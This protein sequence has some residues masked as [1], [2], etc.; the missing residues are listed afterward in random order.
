MS[1]N[2]KVSVSVESK[3]QERVEKFL[4]KRKSDVQEIADSISRAE[5][6]SIKMMGEL[7]KKSAGNFGMED[8]KNLGQAIETAAN[9]KDSGKLKE[10]AVELGA[11]LE[12]LE[13]KY[14]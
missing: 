5:Y 9:I 2:G 3:H 4:T 11:Y 7:I 8:L 13:V 12:S 6:P 10:L 14:V 1:V